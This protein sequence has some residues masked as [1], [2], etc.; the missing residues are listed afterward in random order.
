MDVPGKDLSVASYDENYFESG[1]NLLTAGECE[2]AVAM[3]DSAIKLGL[4]D[5]AAIHVCRAEALTQLGQWDEVYLSAAS[6]E[7]PMEIEIRYRS[8]IMT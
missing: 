4:G 3:F 6:A 2:A 8:R 1:L 7:M 5:L